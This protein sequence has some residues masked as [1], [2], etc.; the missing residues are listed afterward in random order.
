MKTRTPVETQALGRKL[1]RLLKGLDVVCLYGELGSGKTTMTKGIAAGA[2]FRGRVMSPTF[3]L[4]RLYRGKR[5]TLNHLDLYR[6]GAAETGDIGL[7]DFLHDPKAA[8]VIEWPQAGAAYYPKD[9][10]E[11]RLSHAADGRRLAFKAMGRRSRELLRRLE[12][13]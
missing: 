2:G 6:V 7:E 10:L 11:V 9:R 8:C 5:L 13:A 12:S 1:G 3:G 4:A